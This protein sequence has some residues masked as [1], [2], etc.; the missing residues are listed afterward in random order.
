MAPPPYLHRR[1]SVPILN[2]TATSIQFNLIPPPLSTRN[3]RAQLTPLREDTNADD[4]THALPPLFIAKTRKVVSPPV[5][6]FFDA[7]SD[8]EERAL[9]KCTLCHGDLPLDSKPYTLPATL[10]NSLSP[11]SSLQGPSS[12]SPSNGADARKSHGS[13][14]VFCRDCYVWIYNL[15]ICWSC[16]E[17]VG[18]SEERVG[19][20]WCWWHW[21]CYGCLLCRVSGS[22]M[23]RKMSCLR[24]RKLE[25]QKKWLRRHTSKTDCAWNRRL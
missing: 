2:R 16:G 20:G 5:Q 19:F 21:G 9:Y 14:R 13:G 10:A 12:S 22:Q 3:S 24:K 4:A 17:I 8:E 1:L 25:G 11:P 23:R 6:V 18:R 7:D 15:G